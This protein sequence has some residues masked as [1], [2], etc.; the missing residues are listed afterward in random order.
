MLEFAQEVLDDQ[1]PDV[2]E[3]RDQVGRARGQTERLTKLA[4]E[5]LDLSRIDA[6]VPLR[7]EP[8]ELLALARSVAG[9]FAPGDG[10]ALRVEGRE[11]WA[12]ADPGAPR[13]SCASSPTT[14]CATRRPAARC[15]IQV[16]TTPRRFTRA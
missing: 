1:P 6:G 11:A 12:A 10:R 3:A 14:R 5:L 2:E 4:A 9:E 13:G 7:V 8:I 15:P 16:G